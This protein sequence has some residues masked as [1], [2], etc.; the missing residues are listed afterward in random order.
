MANLSFFLGQ[1]FFQVYIEFLTI[2]ITMPTGIVVNDSSQKSQENSRDP[3]ETLQFTEK[4]GKNE[5]V[6]RLPSKWT[7]VNK[8]QMKLRFSHCSKMYVLNLT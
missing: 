7:S 4:C 2:K 8:M 3:W 5:S 1:P 6:D